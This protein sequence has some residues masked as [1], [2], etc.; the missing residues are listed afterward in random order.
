MWSSGGEACD[1]IGKGARDDVG[2]NIGNDVG[3]CTGNK[4]GNNAGHE[5]CNGVGDSV[6]NGVG[7][8]VLGRNVGG[9]GRSKCCD[10]QQETGDLGTKTMGAGTRQASGGQPG[11]AISEMLMRSAKLED[12]KK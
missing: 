10:W 5:V 4:A 7:N 8:G 1:D 9:G 12:S 6:D 11:V 3:K 2:D